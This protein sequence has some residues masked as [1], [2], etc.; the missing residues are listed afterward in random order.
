M[1][2]LLAALAIMVSI[3]SVHADNYNDPYHD[4]DEFSSSVTKLVGFMLIGR[5]CGVTDEAGAERIVSVAV[6]LLGD[7]MLAHGYSQ[8]ET[9]RDMSQ[10]TDFT[11]NRMTLGEQRD[12][13]SD[14]V[15]ADGR[16]KK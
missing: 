8:E 2:I 3:M 12:F 15:T 1:K 4:P 16:L 6:K 5:Y 10:I 9:M 7:V 14:L 11:W 13:C